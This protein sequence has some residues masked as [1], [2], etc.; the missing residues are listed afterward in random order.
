MTVHAP[1]R[2]TGVLLGAA[3]AHALWSVVPVL[4]AAV[5]AL[6]AR[7]RR[8]DGFLRAHAA[9]AFRLQ[10]L[11]AVVAGVLLLPANVGDG[12][13]LYGDPYGDPYTSDALSQVGG[14]LAVGVGL[15]ACVV[16]VLWLVDAAEQ[17]LPRRTVGPA[18]VLVPRLRVVVGP[19]G[20]SGAPGRA[21]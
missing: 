18:A 2:G 12:A 14:L 19:S 9:A 1:G 7:L 11:S 5:L 17:R 21:G 10:G 6:A 16:S 20:A 3:S 8:V 4:G 13:G 15:Y